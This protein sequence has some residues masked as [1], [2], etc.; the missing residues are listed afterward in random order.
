MVCSRWH[1]MMADASMWPILDVTPRE[2]GV[3]CPSIHHNVTNM[4]VWLRRRVA[5][6]RELTVWA[7][8]QCCRG[9]YANEI[10]HC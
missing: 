7:S 2:C 6:M 10:L 1:E 4:E 5:G 9:Q 3:Y 8:V